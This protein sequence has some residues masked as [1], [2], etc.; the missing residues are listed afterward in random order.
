MLVLPKPKNWRG[1]PSKFKLYAANES[2]INVYKEKILSVN[3]EKN[4]VLD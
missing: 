3:F 4:T 2:I 1:K